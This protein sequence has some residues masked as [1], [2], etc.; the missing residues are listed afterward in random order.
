MTKLIKTFSIGKDFSPV[1]AGR[2]Y[3]DGSKSGEAFRTELVAPALKAGFNVVVDLDDAEGF[4]SSFLEEAF[5]GL[6]RAHGYSSNEVLQRVTILSKLDP[7]LVD[8]IVDYI[9]NASN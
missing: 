6:V 3:S 4:G 5:G 9:R 1:P 8:E 2:Y 7:S